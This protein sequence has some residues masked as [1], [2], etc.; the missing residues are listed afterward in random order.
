MC[1][2]VLLRRPRDLWPLVIAANR[3]EMR[4]RPGLPP[5]RHW[6]ERPGVIGGRDPVGGGSWLAV[7]DR[8]LVAAVLNRRGSLGPAAGK[9]SRGELVLK[10]L[11]HSGARRAAAALA[12]IDPGAWRSFNLVVADRGEA[13]WLRHAGDGR[14]TVRPLGDGLTMLTAG[15]ADDPT[16]ARIRRHR[17]RFLRLASPAPDNPDWRGWQRLLAATA[18]DTADPREAMCIRTEGGYGTVSASILAFPADPAAAPL[19]LYADGPPDEAPFRPVPLS[20]PAP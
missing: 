9:R 19:W 16:C 20:R 10:A 15:E 1:T 11:E 12:R 13:F 17:P 18:E 14:I 3:D 2:L 6:P 7:A 8:G 5:G 4:D